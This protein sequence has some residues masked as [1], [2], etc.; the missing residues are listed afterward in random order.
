MR[1]VFADG[2]SSAEAT[3]SVTTPA[4]VARPPLVVMPLGDS[5]TLGASQPA[6]VPGGYR[7]PL[8]T[9]LVNAG[10]SIQFVGS[11]PNN[12]T[13]ALTAAGNAAH[14]GHGSYKT[15][16]LLANLDA[17][18][19]GPS[20]NNGGFWLTGLTG[21][22]PALYPDVIL[23]MA[24]VNDLGVNQ[25]P[26]EQGLAGF[27]ALL[28]KLA[29]LR[30]SAWIMVSTLTPYIGAGVSEPRGEPAEPSTP[31]CPRWSPVIR[32][33]GIGSPGATCGRG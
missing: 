10:Y 19:A 24:G 30:P 4:A 28:N 32:P 13:A 18:V 11:D 12:P 29:T 16:D 2:G 1:G 7:D 20:A 5:I 27:D 6:W 26:P 8:H 25:L 33:P 23:L 21:V 17:N 22:R 3:A 9:L 14:E 31:R 15:T